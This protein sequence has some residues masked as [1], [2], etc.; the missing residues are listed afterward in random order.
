MGSAIS[1]LAVWACTACG[2]CV[3]ICPVGN[4][5]MFDILDIRRDAV[6]MKGDFPAELQVAFNGMERQGNPWGIRE[7]RFKWAKGLDS[8][9]QWTTTPNFDILYWMGCAVKLRSTRATDGPCAGQGA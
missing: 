6:L 1:E 4:E 2:A 3:D 9:Q 7:S 5:P 8:C